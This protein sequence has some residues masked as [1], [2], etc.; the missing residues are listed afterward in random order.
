MDNTQS[1]P[2]IK[3]PA[4]GKLSQYSKQ[5]KSH[6]DDNKNDMTN[7]EPMDEP[8]DED[9]FDDER[10]DS[11]RTNKQDPVEQ[12]VEETKPKS[13]TSKTNLGPRQMS[14]VSGMKKNM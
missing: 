9:N 10:F 7:P 13:S 1:M 3:K 14:G 11:E 12:E 5:F 6:V 4:S 8:E 2:S